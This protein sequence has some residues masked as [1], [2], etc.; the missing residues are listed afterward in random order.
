MA[1][2]LEITVPK[3][4]T[5]YEME[6]LVKQELLVMGLIESNSNIKFIKMNRINYSFL[7]ATTAFE[8]WCEAVTEELRKDITIFGP[9]SSRGLFFTGDCLRDLYYRLKKNS[10]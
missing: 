10:M 7:N 4:Y 6:E 1:Y 3:T 2:T 8:N 5:V 9:W